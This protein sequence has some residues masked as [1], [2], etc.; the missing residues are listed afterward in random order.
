MTVDSLDAV[1]LTAIFILPGFIMNGIIDKMNP[2]KRHSEGIFF[3]KYLAYSIINCACWSWLYTIILQA[4]AE[5]HIVLWV[6][7]VATTIVGSTVLAIIIS[8]LKQKNIAGVILQKMKLN[9][10]HSTPSAW[11]YYFSK[12][13][14]SFVIITMTDG[15]VL[16]GWYSGESFS[17]SDYEER[18]IFVE[19][20][21]RI[22]DN[23]NWI[24]DQESEGFYVP[25]DQIR[26]I[27]FKRGA[28]DKNE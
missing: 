1:F 3:L 24:L 23:G 5:H 21:Y 13:K 17:S 25:K 19:R 2:P 4:S 16:R 7:L 8:V 28:D 15:S 11:D 18:D 10:I 27:E 22:D 14:P 12:L 20:S 9:P 6:L 26:F